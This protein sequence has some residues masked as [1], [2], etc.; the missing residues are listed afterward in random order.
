MGHSFLFSHISISS[1]RFST[2]VAWHLPQCPAVFGWLKFPVRGRFPG[3][4]VI[5]MMNL[6]YEGQNIL[7]DENDNEE[8]ANLIKSNRF[9]GLIAV[10]FEGRRLYV[11]L[12]EHVP[13]TVEFK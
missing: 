2:V 8:L 3:R 1:F 13:F 12:S 10:F 11:N 4:E 6:Y 7:L 9:P 5:K